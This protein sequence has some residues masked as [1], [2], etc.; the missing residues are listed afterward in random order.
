MDLI[1]ITCQALLISS[2][3]TQLVQAEGS[4][5][6]S[7]SVY[8]SQAN[9]LNKQSGYRLQASYLNSDLGGVYLSYGQIS[10]YAFID[11]DGF[12]QAHDLPIIKFGYKLPLELTDNINLNIHLGAATSLAQITGVN[13]IEHE[14]GTT[15]LNLAAEIEWSLTPSWS[16]NLGMDKVNNMDFIGS[17]TTANLGLRYKFSSTSP[18]KAKTEKVAWF[19]GS[20]Q[21]SAQDK[22][23]RSNANQ[24]V[25]NTETKILNK[26]QVQAITQTQ[27]SQTQQSNLNLPV[28]AESNKPKIEVESKP[29]VT[30]KTEV[31]ANTKTNETFYKVQ[32]AAFSNPANAKELATKLANLGYQCK[33]TQ[34]GNFQL[35]SVA[36]DYT[37]QMAIKV[38]AEIK[39]QLRIDGIVRIIK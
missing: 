5:Q 37:E 24:S 7:T 1:K 12:E 16:V 15:G 35:V 17:V 20:S 8:A 38:K 18:K 28:A 21:A 22:R 25:V 32:L 6:I 3:T 39:Q 9:Q 14:R 29:I 30:P 13:R 33:I 27:K 23:I 2:L 34:S 10:Q 4:N 31:I 11:Q 36:A 19:T 26:P